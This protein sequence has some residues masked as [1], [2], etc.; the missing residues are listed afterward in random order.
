[1]THRVPER[2]VYFISDG[3]G[4]TAETI[5]HSL[6]TQFGSLR[7]DTRRLAFID[8]EEKARAA[9]TLVREQGRIMGCRPI[10]ISS[11]VNEALSALL[12]ESGA[13]AL[14]VLGPFVGRLETEL[15]QPREV[16]GINFLLS[17]LLLVWVADIFA[18]FAGRA[19]GAI[20][21]SSNLILPF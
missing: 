5:G 14:D 13:L 8:N 2:L 7:F 10:I 16:I 1:M 6:L 9:A 19:F 11:V 3:T 20:F 15:G 4:I 18:Y 21:Q 12:A 17:I